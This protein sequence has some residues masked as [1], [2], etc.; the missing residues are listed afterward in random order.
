MKNY[1]EESMNLFDEELRST[2]SSPENQ[3]L[4]NIDDSS[5]RLENKD[6]DILH[7]IVAK[8]L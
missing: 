5:T 8:Q 7:F 4:Q 1:I 6:A 3:G 2:V